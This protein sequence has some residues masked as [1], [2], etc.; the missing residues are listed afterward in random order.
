M[1]QSCAGYEVIGLLQVDKCKKLFGLMFE[2]FSTSWRTVKTMSKQPQPLQ[3]MADDK[4]IYAAASGLNL[5]GSGGINNLVAF[6]SSIS[7]INQSQLTVDLSRS[8][9]TAANTCTRILGNKN[10]DIRPYSQD[11]VKSL[12]LTNL[13]LSQCFCPFP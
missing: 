11:Y 9:L 8:Q 12:Y 13:Q 1:S 4:H 2:P 5:N 6:L 7:P 3:N 10:D